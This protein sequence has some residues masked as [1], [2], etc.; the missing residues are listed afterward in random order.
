MTQKR[1]RECELSGYGRFANSAF[2]GENLLDGAHVSEGSLVT[3]KVTD[4]YD[5]FHVFKGHISLI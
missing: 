3:R 1:K 2:A 4:K 5:V